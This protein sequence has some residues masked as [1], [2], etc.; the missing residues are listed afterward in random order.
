MTLFL[1]WVAVMAL[2]V[3]DILAQSKITDYHAESELGWTWWMN[4]RDKRITRYPL[5]SIVIYFKYRRF[6]NYKDEE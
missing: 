1:Y 6:Y 2:L 3:A 5:G 4:S